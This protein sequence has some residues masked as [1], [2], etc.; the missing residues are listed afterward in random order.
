MNAGDGSILAMQDVGIGY[1]QVD[2]VEKSFFH[3]FCRGL[4]KKCV[5]LV[6]L[7]GNINPLMYCT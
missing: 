4:P 6:H 3:H 1:H 2:E 7:I 5:V